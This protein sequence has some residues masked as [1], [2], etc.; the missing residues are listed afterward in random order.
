MVIDY[1]QSI[2]RNEMQPKQLRGDRYLR[3]YLPPPHPYH[4][5]PLI[6]SFPSISNLFYTT[7]SF[8]DKM[9]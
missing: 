9:E 7:T 5:P 4:A 8:L 6:H 1:L 3:L 2:Y